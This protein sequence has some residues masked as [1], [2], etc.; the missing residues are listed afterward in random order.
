MRS[1][2]F[3][4]MIVCAKH[5]LLALL[6]T[7]ILSAEPDAIVIASLQSSDDALAVPPVSPVSPLL[8]LDI[9]SLG[10]EWQALFESMHAVERVTALF[11]ES[12][13]FAFRKKPRRYRGV[14]RKEADGRVS[15][16]YTEPEKMVLHIGDGFA[17]Y[18]KE[19]GTIRRIP[20]SNTQGAALALMPRL[21]NF[22]LAPIAEYYEISGFMEGA[23]WH[24]AFDAKEDSKEE[25]PYQRME[26]IGQGT[27]V[28]RI[29]LTKSEKQSILIEMGE[30]MYPEFFL[31]EVKAAYFFFP[32][33]E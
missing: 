11:G 33:S 14:F 9:A 31:P 25:L 15:L 29:E 23:D 10:A 18:R 1:L 26:V 19:A 17:Y 2:H 13:S 12:R 20:N 28:Q 3:S 5:Y 22:D 16:A 8:P 32:E 6:C 7:V 27:A 4:S 24:L 21:L 30:P